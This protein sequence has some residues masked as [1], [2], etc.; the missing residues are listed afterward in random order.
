MQSGGMLQVDP[1]DSRRSW[2]I[3][4][5]NFFKKYALLEKDREK[6]RQEAPSGLLR[7]FPPPSAC[8]PSLNATPYGRRRDSVQAEASDHSH[9]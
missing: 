6:R 1:G 9:R 2:A 8:T 3:L 5:Q 7:N 4:T